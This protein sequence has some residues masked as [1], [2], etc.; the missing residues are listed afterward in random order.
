MNAATGMTWSGAR[1]FG[2][3]PSKGQTWKEFGQAAKSCAA[4]SFGLSTAAGAT[5]VASGLPVLST[6]AKPL[7]MTVGTSVASN[8]FRSVLPQT[9]GRTWAP[10]LLTPLATSTTLGGVVGRWVPIVGEAI[11]VVQGG[12]FVSCLWASDDNY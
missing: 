8:F 2:L 7:G 6:A 3:A 11:L 12:N 9:I 5:G 1:A 4:S 10:T